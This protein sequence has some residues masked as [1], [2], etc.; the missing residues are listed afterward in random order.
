MLSVIEEASRPLPVVFGFSGTELDSDEREFFKQ[1]CPFGFILFARNCDTQEQL[2]RLTD[3]LRDCAGRDIPVLIDQEG[4]RVMR[5]REPHWRDRPAAK[6]FGDMF[7]T[8]PD[9]AVEATRIN[10]NAISRELSSAGI[11]VNCMPVLDVLNCDTHRSIGDRAFS[12]D[13]DIVANLAGQVCRTLLADDIIPVVKHLPGQGRA[14]SDSHRTLPVVSAALD[15]LRKT[16]F[17]PFATVLT[18][19][20]S[21]A[22]WGMVA[23]VVYEAIDSHLPAS[24]SCRLIEESIRGDIGFNGLLLSDDIGMNALEEYGHAAERTNMALKA[25]C[26][27]VLHCNGKMDEMRNIAN[28]TPKMTG[29]A[30]KRYNRSV[31]W[32]EH[33]IL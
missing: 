27:I 30:V 7:D 31:E 5:L 16:D 26:D 22:V 13:P 21:C 14:L 10:A 29:R 2:R 6:S 4:G 19:D 3:E 25:G 33:G 12:S 23:H 24:C 8:D 32:L 17:A 18:K 28:K 15:D 11:N 9:K 20:V 1:A